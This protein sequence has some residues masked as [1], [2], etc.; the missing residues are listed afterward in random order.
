MS[1]QQ[2]DSAMHANVQQPHVQAPPPPPQQQVISPGQPRLK[3]VPQAFNPGQQGAMT[4]APMTGSGAPHQMQPQHQQMMFGGVA[5]PPHSQQQQPTSS[6]VHAVGTPRAM[7]LNPQLVWSPQQML[8]P[9]GTPAQTV[10]LMEMTPDMIMQAGFDP[11]S[12]IGV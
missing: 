10:A 5:P 7:Q 12:V 2:Y 6:Q 9:V 11:N 1:Q 3:S 8:T 4:M